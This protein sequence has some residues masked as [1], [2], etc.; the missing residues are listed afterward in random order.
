MTHHLDGTEYPV[1]WHDT[2]IEAVPSFEPRFD[3]YEDYA[4]STIDDILTQKEQDAATRLTAETFETS[5]FVTQADG[6]FRRRALPMETQFAPIQGLAVRDVNADGRPDLLLAGNDFTVRPQWGRADAEKG[7]VLLN[8][9]DLQ[10]KGRGSRESGFYAPTDVRD[11]VIVG[12]GPQSLLV[13]GNNNA[14]L[15]TF[16]FVHSPQ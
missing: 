6:P 3:S 15:S 12:E 10:F 1:Y 13:L 9:G 5:L 14:T 7:T 2:L 16:S 4:T 8:Q 11:L